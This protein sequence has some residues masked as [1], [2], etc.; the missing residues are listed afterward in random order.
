MSFKQLPKK[1]LLRTAREDFAVDVDKN[2]TKAEIAQQLEDAGVTFD[3]YV[4]LFPEEKKEEKSDDNNVIR[5]PDAV[6]EKLTPVRYPQDASKER[7]RERAE[8]ED[9]VLI[10]MDRANLY[11]EVRGYKFSKAH[12][13]QLVKEEDVDYLTLDLHGFR[14]AT[15]REVKEYY[16]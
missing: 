7:A 13:F 3:Q 5:R 1:E 9:L 12:P 10:K 16:S 6:E 15:P 2:D 4:D 11:Y 14:M 8:K